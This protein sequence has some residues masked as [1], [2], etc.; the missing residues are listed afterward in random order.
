[1]IRM[2][3]KLILLSCIA[4]QVAYADVYQKSVVGIEI[5]VLMNGN[6]PTGRAQNSTGSLKTN[7]GPLQFSLTSP[8]YVSN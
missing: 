2:K 5:A 6:L 4:W 3:V 1:M 8:S 7:F